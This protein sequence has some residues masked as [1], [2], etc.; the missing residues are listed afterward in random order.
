MCDELRERFLQAQLKGDRREA[1]R[2]LI[3]DGVN[4]G[5]PVRDLQLKVVQEAQREIGRLWQENVVS[6]AQEHLATAIAN[7]ALSHLYNLAPNARRNGRV[8]LVACVDGEL[9]EFPARLVADALDLAGFDVRYLGA[10]VPVDSLVAMVR[11]QRPDL[12]ALSA[13]MTFNL[14]ALRA[15]VA[16]LREAGVATPVVAGVPE[17]G[18]A[19]DL[20][21]EDNVHVARGTAHDLVST[22]R[23]VL[24]VPA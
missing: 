21:P 24:G 10:S 5:I 8:A 16:G 17:V 19:P 4:A 2:L 22:V 11:D 23:R 20:A 18:E 9:H 1:L 3:D 13:T 14:P 7:V 15:A 12:V 6:I